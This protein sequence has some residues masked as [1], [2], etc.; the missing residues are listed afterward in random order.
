MAVQTTTNTAGTT[1]LNKT[2]YDKNLL[3]NAKSQLC[4]A[5]YGQTRSIP[6]N[7]GDNVEFRRW[8][9]FDPAAIIGGLTEGVTPDAQDIKQTR[10]TA[11]VKEYGAYVEVSDLLKTTAFDD[12]VEGATD[13]LGEQMGIAIEWI[14]RDAMS[15][16][17]NV[18]YAG[19]NTSRLALDATDVL[20]TTEIRKAVRYLKKQKARTFTREGGKPHFIAIVSPDAVYDLQNDSVWQAVSEYSN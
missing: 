13:L 6:K 11:K 5:K 10:V 7:N 1:Y 4:H 16:G 12:V 19:G 15:E 8:T 18:Q 9:A 17:T 14:T 3:E 20:T 2:Y